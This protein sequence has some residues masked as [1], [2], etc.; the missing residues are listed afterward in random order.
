MAAVRTC[1]SSENKASLASASAASVVL[2]GGNDNT[3]RLWE[4]A[5]GKPLG[6]PLQQ[7]TVWAVAFSRDGK[8]M[9]TRDFQAAR[10]WDAATGKPLGRPMQHF[11]RA[12][13]FSPDGK[14]VLTGGERDKA[15]QL[16]NVGTGE[17]MGPPLQHLA[18]VLAVALS[19]DGKTA[20]TA[21][22]DRTARLWDVA[23]AKPLGP[24]VQLQ[25]WVV[26]VAFSPDGK[27][28]LVGSEDRTA[29][30]WP[31]PSPLQ[32]NPDRIAL[33]LQVATGMEL[34]EHGSIQVLDAPLWQARGQQLNNVAQMP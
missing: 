19:P 11:G 6:P 14:T 22:R 16:W 27:T 1:S 28:V 7:G 30:L 32:G 15:A 33:W 5:S 24:P 23:T 31:V 17:P 34:D 21:S 3:A 29:R 9:L 13:A 10:L 18:E 4:A 26:A 12:M 25:N 20:L 2:T 8:I